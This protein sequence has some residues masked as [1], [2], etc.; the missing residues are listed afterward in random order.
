MSKANDTVCAMRKSA[1]AVLGEDR[2]E[3][4]AL[5]VDR[6]VR[7]PREYSVTTPLGFRSMP[8]VWMVYTGWRSRSRLPAGA[9]VVYGSASGNGQYSSM[10]SPD[11]G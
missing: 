1:V 7:R 6:H 2:L 5:M 3:D 11:S 4:A 8:E 10:S 9:N